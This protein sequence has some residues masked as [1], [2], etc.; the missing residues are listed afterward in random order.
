MRRII[1][2]LL[3]IPLAISLEAQK[4]RQ[5]ATGQKT[6]QRCATDEYLQRLMAQDP[7]LKARLLE[8]ETRLA[9]GMDARLQRRKT[10]GNNR[11]TAVVTIPVVVH[12]V[13]SNPNIVTDADIAWQIN[14]MNIDFAG[15]N[16]DSVKALAFAPLFGH[17]EIQFC[18]AQR[19]PQGNPTTG[20]DRVTSARGWNQTNFN[21]LKHASNCGADSWDPAKYLNIWVAESEDGTLGV[22]T[23]PTTGV[24]AEQGVVIAHESFGNNAAYVSPNFNL[25]RTAVHEIGHYFFGRHIW[26]DGGGCNSDFPTVAGLTGSW[27]D[28]TPTQSGPTSGCP[29]GTRDAGC[30]SPNPPGRMYQNYMDYTND[31][32]YCMFTKN[33]VLRMETA[34]EL[35][36]A[37]LMSSDGCTAPTP[38]ANDAAIIAILSPFAGNGCAPSNNALCSPNLVS[39][40]TLKNYGSANLTSVTIYTQIDGGTPVPYNWTGNLAPNATINVTL[41]AVTSVVG[42]HTLKIYT[43]NPNGAADGRPTNDAANSSFT[44]L[45]PVTIPLTQGFESVTFP[46]PGWFVINGNAGSHTWQRTTVAAKSGAASA[47]LP[48]YDYPN[49]DGHVDYL[50]SPPIAVTANQGLVLSFER[51]YRL[52]STE[53]IYADS[54]AVVISFDCGA[55]FTEVWKRGGAQL[56]TVS[57][58]TENAFVPTVNQWAQAFVN[59]QPYITAAGNMIVGFKG[60]NLYGNHLYIDNINIDVPGI[61]ITDAQI[62]QIVSPFVHECD[63]NVVPQ[64][65]LRN[66][67]NDTLKKVSIVLLMDNANAGTINWTGSILPG[68]EALVQ[69]VNI[70]IPA[71][72]NH[73]LKAYTRQPNDLPDNDNSNDTLSMPFLVH[74]PQPLPVQE[75]F[76]NTVFPPP[77]WSV[78]SSGGNYT[79]ERTTRAA[80]TGTGSVWIRNYRFNSNFRKDDLYSPLVQPGEYDSMIVR[81]DVAHA[82][83]GAPVATPDTLEVLVTKDCGHT[84]TSVYKKWGASLQTTGNPPPVFSDTVGFIPNASQW[85]REY[86]DITEL[87]DDNTDFMVVFR[88]TSHNGNNTFLDN[89]NIDPVLLPARLKKEGFIITPNPFQG[90]FV[91]RHLVAPTGLRTVVVTNTA[92]QMVFVQHFGGNATTSIPVDLQR[93]A[94]GMYNV[95]LIYTYRTANVK[96]IKL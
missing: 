31:Q 30:G 64:V 71:G 38:V 85:R 45:T 56:A 82:L 6:L 19:D 7:G 50:L 72:L 61:T 40:V 90:S 44:V 78:I 1:L 33:Q 53:D 15:Q 75:G 62:S 4:I 27:T 59:L 93:Y 92:G 65:R 54:L 58:T 3:F 87:V 23:F 84:F 60:T 28:D 67:G 12:I 77:H 88:N 55:T 69:G 80:A 81:F 39:R 2:C 51:A 63:R 10:Q 36:R 79:W 89:I 17:S 46:P 42:N 86:I 25:G 70:N 11:L 18:L 76:E 22:A 96:L 34:L 5:S 74:D 37:S 20:I 95:K 9:K 73:T 83:S 35:F 66:N 57:G 52:F 49:G 13:L 8:T 41:P 68:N 26:G 48:Y 91:I 24:A 43:A 32:C 21:E 47:F 29:T 14:K 16:P 94:S